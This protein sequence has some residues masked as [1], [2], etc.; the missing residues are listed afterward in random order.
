M[1]SGLP[2]TEA[3]KP[4]SIAC[5]DWLRIDISAPINAGSGSLRLR[6]NALGW[7]GCRAICA[8][9]SEV[10]RSASSSVKFCMNL[11]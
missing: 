2:Q 9:S 11:Q 4:S 7:S 6:A 3:K 10:I 8:N 5:C 1:K